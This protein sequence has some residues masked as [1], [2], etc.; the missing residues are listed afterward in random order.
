MILFTLCTNNNLFPPQ[1]LLVTMQFSIAGEPGKTSE[2][3]NKRKIQ[4]ET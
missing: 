2:Y 4:K 1:N 3:R